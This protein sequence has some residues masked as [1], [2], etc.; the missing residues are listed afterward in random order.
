[1]PLYIDNIQMPEPALKGITRQSNKVW[2]ASTG[3]SVSA[4]LNGSIVEIKKKATFKFPPLTKSEL[5]KLEGAVSDKTAFHNIK[6][7]DTDGSVV[8]SMTVYF[9]DS[10]HTVYSSAKKQRYFIDYT[11]DAIE[12]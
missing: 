6:Y 4:L 9:G 3:R 1:M 2:D 7:T 12:R 11:F 5:D 10:S 8:L